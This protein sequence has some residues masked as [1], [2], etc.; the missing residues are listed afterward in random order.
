VRI[1][2]ESEYELVVLPTDEPV[3]IEARS[4]DQSY[5]AFHMLASGFGTC[6]LSVLHTW[7]S[8]AEL[9]TGQL[10]VRVKWSFAEEPH[11]VGRYELR[12]QWPD[13]P[14][15]RIAAAQRVVD[16]CAVHETFRH[17]PEIDV[18]IES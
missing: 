5:S 7:A 3:T 12:I 18:Q 15:D 13:L 2:L 17:P 9:P 10:S 4:P 6:V 1:I 8:S 14:Q 16:L 11:R